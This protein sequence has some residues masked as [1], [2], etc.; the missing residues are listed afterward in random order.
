MQLPNPKSRIIVVFGLPRALIWSGQ[1]QGVISNSKTSSDSLKRSLRPLTCKLW[2]KLFMQSFPS[3]PSAL[4]EIH[5]GIEKANTWVKTNKF[6]MFQGNLRITLV[7]KI[8]L[9]PVMCRNLSAG[10]GNFLGNNVAEINWTKQ[11]ILCWS[12]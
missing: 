10:L 2:I 4:V 12:C 8:I 1:A 6:R 11:N 9:S 3:N 7:R 5:F